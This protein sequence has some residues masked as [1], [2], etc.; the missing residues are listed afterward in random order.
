[1]RASSLPAL[2][3]MPALGLLLAL[4]FVLGFGRLPAALPRLDFAAMM[5]ILAEAGAGCKVSL[6]SIL[7]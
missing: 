5:N 4:V 2:A 6:R 3:F 7:R 1:M